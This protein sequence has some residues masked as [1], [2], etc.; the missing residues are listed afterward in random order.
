MAEQVTINISIGASG[1][2]VTPTGAFA[3]GATAPPSPMALE[4]L[5]GTIAALAPAPRS[6]AELARIGF[7]V[8]EEEGPPPLPID[9]LTTSAAAAPGPVDAL[10]GDFGAPPPPIQGALGAAEGAPGPR[11][12]DKLGAPGGG[13]SAG[14]GQGEIQNRP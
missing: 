3:G 6:P 4:E 10:T 2:S 1:V 12:L 14:D 8:V 11:P 13:E 7:G 5:Q 9:Q